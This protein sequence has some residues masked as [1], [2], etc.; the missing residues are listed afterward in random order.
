MG[1]V[2]SAVIGAACGLRTFS[3]PAALAVH[4]GLGGPRGRVAIVA[5]AVGELVGDKLPMTPARTSPPALAGRIVAGAFCG[6]RVGG[7]AGA[8]V[9]A[10]A[11]VMSAFAGMRARGEVVR[12]LKLPDP[13]VAVGEDAV[14]YVLAG[15]VA[16]Q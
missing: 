2:D 13:V 5:V 9:G 7:A 10:A 14:A 6:Q 12:A 16:R 15:Y 3:G 1:L 11:A 8:G 4:R